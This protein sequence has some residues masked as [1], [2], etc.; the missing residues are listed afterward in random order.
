MCYDQS[1]HR[2]KATRDRETLTKRFGLRKS[3]RD[4]WWSP[5]FVSLVYQ[6]G[7]GIYLHQRLEFEVTQGHTLVDSIGAYRNK[8]PLNKLNVANTRQIQD[9][10]R[11]FYRWRH[12]FNGD[13]AFGILGMRQHENLA[14][15][16]KSFSFT[17]YDLYHVNP[18]ITRQ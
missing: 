11:Y 6:V 13:G 3:M 5:Y 12:E 15:Y 10:S 14:W 18:L 4:D 1:S 8:C 2:T 9:T 7:G 17:T 16:V